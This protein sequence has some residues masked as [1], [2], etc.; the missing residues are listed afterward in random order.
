MRR[1]L[2]AILL[3]LLPVYIFSQTDTISDD[4]ED[5]DISNW[6]Q[7]VAATWDAT[8]SSP[9]SGSYSLQ[10]TNA[11]GSG[12]EQISI[13]FSGIEITLGI[14]TWRFQVKHSFN[15]SSQNNWAVFLFS[16]KD[17]TEM[18]NGGTANGYAVGVD[19]TGSDDLIKLWRIDNGSLTEII[20]T[21][22]NCQNSVGTANA[23]GFEITRTAS[24]DWTLKID[25]VNGGF[26]SLVNAGTVNDNT[27]STANYFGIFYEYSSTHVTDFQFDDLQII[28]AA[29]NNDDSYISAGADTEPATISSLINDADG[30][31]V[32]D[33]TFNDAGTSDGKP[34]I[35]DSLFFSQAT[36]NDIQDWTSVIAGAKLF[37]ND[38]PS[39]ISGT[40]DSNGISFAKDSLFVIDDNSM[41]T[42]K[43]Q[44]WLKNSLPDTVDNKNLVFKLDYNDI[45]TNISGSSFGA[46]TVE[47]GDN[48]NAIDIQASKLILFDVPAAVAQNTDF[49][50][51]V[52]ATDENG[53]IDI[54]ATNSVILSAYNGTGNLSS[55]SGLS[56]NLINGNFSWSDLQYDQLGDFQIIAS[57]S[58]LTSDTSASIECSEYIYY[59]QDDFEDG[60]LVG[61]EANEPSHWQASDIEPINGTYS[62][63]Q[64]YDASTYGN[65]IISYQLPNVDLSSDSIIW[66]FQLKY[67]YNSPSSTNNW[68]IFLSADAD[69]SEMFNGGNINGYVL[70]VNFSGTDDLLK[71]WRVDNGSAT[72]IISTSFDWNTT[73][74]TS[75]KGFIVSRSASGLWEVKIDENGG[76]DNLFSLGT[77][78]DTTYST[79]NYFGVEYKYSSTHDKILWLD[80]VYMGPP[81]P[82]TQAPWVDTVYAETPNTLKILFN[83]DVSNASVQTLSNFSVDNGIGNPQTASLSGIN[84]RLV[85]LTFADNFQDANQYTISIQNIEDESEN[86]I[87]D[88]SITFVWN[89]ITIASL[90]FLTTKKF[91]IKFTKKVDATTAEILDNYNVLDTIGN[92]ITAKVDS[93]DSTIVHLSFEK[94]MQ[95]AGNYILHVENIQDKLG[96]IIDPT[97]YPFTFYIVRKN[98]VVINELMIDVNPAP[99]ALP[100]H[101]FIELYN[102]SDFDIDMTDWTMKIGSNNDLTFPQMTIP[103]GGYVVICSDDADSLFQPYGTTVPILK[104]SY[105]TSTT[106]K[107]ITIRN[108]QGNIIEQIKYSPDWYGDPDKDDG[109]WS[110]ERIDPTNFCSQDNNWHVTENY[111]GGTPNMQN[112]VY[113]TNPDTQAPHISSVSLVTSA[114]MTIDYSE[115]VDT[116]QALSMISY[117]LNSSTTPISITLDENDNSIVYLHFLEHFLFSDNSMTIS[118]I[119]DYC[120]NIMPD[121]TITF[122][123]TLVHPTDVEPKS[124]TQLKVYFS[125]PI[126]KSDAENLLNYSVNKGIG[127]P[128]VAT[129]D[130]NDSSVVHLLFNSDFQLDSAYILSMSGIS[131]L[132]GNIMTD[133]EIVFTYH[134]PQPFDIVINEMMLD[135]N[136]A[137]LGLPEAQYIEL[138]NASN[139]DIWLSDWIFIAESQ[140]ERDFPTVK[141]PS[142]GFVLLCNEEDEASLSEFGTTVPILGTTDLTQTGKEL[143]IFDNRNNLIYHVRYS[144]TW[145]NDNTKDDGGW[146]L[147]KIDPYNFCESS[148][149]WQAS[150]DVSGG[151]PGRDNSVYHINND[152]TVPQLTGL[153]VKASNRLF[154]TFSKSLNFDTGLDTANYYV[155][156][157]GYAQSITMSDTSYSAVNIY[158]NEQ[159]ADQKTY[160]LKIQNVTD[161]CGNAMETT[162]KEFTYYLI[163]PEYVW[164]LSDNQ[165]KIKFSEEVEYNSAL[166]KDNYI[167]DNQIGYPNYVV[168]GT[169]DPSEIYLQFDNKFQD[170]QSYTLTISNLKDINDNTMKQ[171]ELTFTYYVAKPNDIVINEILFNPHKG[172]ADFVELYNRSQYSINLLDLTIAKR[173]D[174]GEISSPYKISQQNYM[175][176]PHTYLVLTTDTTDIDST[177]TCG[178]SLLLLDNMPAYPD[179][180]GD[181]VIYDNNDSIIDEFH[182]SADM[183]FALISDDEGVSLERIDYEQPTQDT[184]NWHSAAESAGFATPGLVNSQ[185]KNMSDITTIGEVSLSPQV[186][187]PDN[188]GYNDQLYINYDFDEGGY[189]ADVLIFDKNGILVRHLITDE[190]LGL[191]GYWLWDGLDD[192]QAK[193]RIGMYGIVIKIFDLDGNIHIY[194]KTAVVAGKK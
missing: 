120:G 182:Y 36:N 193:V 20:T 98:D 64:V 112:S 117:I 59:L 137:P 14:T 156:G 88:T 184:S 174:E 94:E 153:S 55:A 83:E 17:A 192:N 21:S 134:V 66:Q 47:S 176:L 27:Y 168:R 175:F 178:D 172:G 115:T 77:A 40:I 4:F 126:K 95:Y 60:D 148:F 75:S 118:G 18:Y 105:L 160:T 139:F 141:I 97:D 147:E 191:S 133:E 63:H 33:I 81:I 48:N 96:N 194:R 170:G 102:V 177:Y 101:K 114:D 155:A 99:V 45:T 132:N 85:T 93:L 78:I 107:Q 38:L 136:P 42:Y 46:G 26:D 25:T 165:L 122:N 106:G 128:I 183:H 123:Y 19:F 151:T 70:G 11:G 22:I 7:N 162:N 58:G 12:E 82:D 167:V 163:H 154:A 56:Q 65:D 103:S 79:A 150:D 24:G 158:F 91:D 149:N 180:E 100:A 109:G 28:G 179:D 161:D 32:F 89:N 90:R 10:H 121:T 143:K 145:Y 113:G 173:D 152:T 87:A 50:I 110:L 3:L 146:S 185:Y 71:L 138:Y 169:E 119:R 34:T 131:D 189:V 181:V 13:P 41:E 35:V 53:N 57:A 111:T 190:L 84:Q 15:P 116:T 171:A 5:G 54:D 130:A 76:F 52:N 159:F 127:N 68:N 30:V 51:S 124:S 125:E 166:I 144:D 43:L 62:L 23:A 135:I 164:T 140:K 49:S 92:P 37:G 44:I 74:E 108:A 86:Q 39:G 6:T 16:D 1:T 67:G 8:T 69:N 157:I 29:G 2:F 73:D 61:W 187:S 31:E 188:D 104:E 80:D 72:A 142:R 129:R 186:F 9:I